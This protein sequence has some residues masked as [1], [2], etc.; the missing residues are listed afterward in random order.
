[1]DYNFRYSESATAYDTDYESTA[2]LSNSLSRTLPADDLG[3]LDSVI[4]N[5]KF[6]TLCLQP[7]SFLHFASGLVGLP[8]YTRFALSSIPGVGTDSKFRLLQNLDEANLSF[9]VLPTTAADALLEST[10][11]EHLA[12]TFNIRNDNLII[13]HIVTMRENDKGAISMTL[14]MKAPIIAD[15]GTQTALQYVLPSNKYDVQQPFKV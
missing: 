5:N 12:K 14:N 13:M 7:E 8:E 9:L 4:I 3:S 1:M 15:A 2:M 11:V 6:G 10:D